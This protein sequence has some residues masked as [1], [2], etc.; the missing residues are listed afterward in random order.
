[1]Y[2]W[3][4]ALAGHDFEAGEAP[5]TD[6]LIG[7]RMRAMVEHYEVSTSDGPITRQRIAAVRADVDRD[8]AKPKTDGKPITNEGV[9]AILEQVKRLKWNTNDLTGQLNHSYSV[10]RS[11]HRPLTRAGRS[12][13]R[14]S[15]R[16]QIPRNLISTK[17][18]SSDT[19]PLP[20]WCMEHGRGG[21]WER[22]NCYT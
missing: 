4:S 14:R 5:D 17:C 1:M 21:V 6:D 2:K 3:A 10:V 8:A 22:R 16:T 11:S 15:N 12:G 18:R 7:R 13:L 20:V 19:S 9:S